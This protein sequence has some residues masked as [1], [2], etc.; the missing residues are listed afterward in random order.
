MVRHVA[1]GAVLSLYIVVVG[2][3]WAVYT[4]A[5]MVA[6]WVRQKGALT[7]I[8]FTIGKTRDPVE[9]EEEPHR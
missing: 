6:L 3:N 9:L 4:S 1:F 8:P 7:S 2:Q 5:L